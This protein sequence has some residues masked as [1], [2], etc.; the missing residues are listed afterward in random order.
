[1][2]FCQYCG[3]QLAD[4][5]ECTC[6]QNASQGQQQSGTAYSQPVNGQY[7]ASQS[8]DATQQNVAGQQNTQ[9]QYGNTSGQYN[10]QGQNGNAAGQYNAQGQYGNATGQ[11]NAQGQ[12]YNTAQNQYTGQNQQSKENEAI[13]DITKLVK[14]ILDTPVAA[15]SEFV[16]KSNITACVILI[17]IYSAIELVLALISIADT[18][19][20][21]AAYSWG[22]SHISI[23]TVFSTI[24]SFVGCEII[25]VLIMAVVIMVVL[26]AMQKNKNVSFAQTLSVACLYNII[27]LP[28]VLIAHVVGLIPF[29]LFGHIDSWIVSFAAAIGY[30][31]TFF[32]IREIEEDDNKMPIVFGLATVASAVCS[33]VVGL[34]L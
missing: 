33:T 26:N 30:V 17:A 28:I 32:G 12:Q 29:N 10:A 8:Q 27:Y 31:Y 7:N 14:G 18:S 11:Y 4:N 3:K 24:F 22:H 9:G 21:T 6:Q 25:Q 23:G 19:I 34:I 16:K 1:M 20:K 15:V 13:N 5:E 2:K